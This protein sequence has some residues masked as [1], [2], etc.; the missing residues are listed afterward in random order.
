VCDAP[1]PYNGFL[2]RSLTNQLDADLTVHFIRLALDSHPWQTPALDGFAWKVFDRRYLADWRFV[3]SATLSRPAVFVIGGWYEMTT[4]LSL[5][6][7]RCPFFIWSDTPNL[8][9]RRHPAKALLR[10]TW[11]RWVFR[12]AA[13]VMGTGQP[14]LDAFAQ[15]GCPTEKLVNF[16]YYID[17]ELFRPARLR[18][19]REPVFLSSGRLH[20]DK[21]YDVAFRA[22]A[23][24]STATGASFRYRIAGVGPAQPEL[25]ALAST[26]G[27]LDRVEF[28]GW[29]EPSDL[30]D[31]YRSGTIFL[32]PARVEPYGVSV[33]EAMASG[34]PVLGSTATG[35]AV[36]RVTPDF[37]G[38]LHEPDDVDSL[39]GQIQRLSDSSELTAEMGRNARQTAERWPV[40]RAVADLTRLL[41]RV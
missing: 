4:Q 18:D 8:T 9:S 29:M 2:F 7:M 33:L 37:N 32:H 31:F 17:L 13:Y 3:R 40:D 15:M 19:E 10:A 24:A 28:L 14:A 27:I 38:L 30:P 35:A 21:G 39:A 36:D 12:R 5:S 41:A 6:V 23:K 16:P 34:L 11:L 26:L 25:A 20:R 1:S 22:L